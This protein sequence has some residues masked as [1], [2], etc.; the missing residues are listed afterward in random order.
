MDEGTRI[1]QILDPYAGRPHELIT[2]LREL[3]HALGYLSGPALTEVSRT[4]KVPESVVYGTATFYSMLSVR[5]RGQHIVRV[6]VS[7]PCHVEGAAAL[8]CALPEEL[9]VSYGQTTPDGFFTL[10]EA[11]CLGHCAEGPVVQ[12]DDNLYFQVTPE[13]LGEILASYRAGTPRPGQTSPILPPPQPGEV[14]IVLERVGQINPD[15]LEETRA[16]GAY[17]GLEKVLAEMT[18]AQLIELVQASGLQGR[19][20]AGFSTGLKWRF[21][22]QAAGDV[23]YV[24]ANADESE[25]GTFKDRLV[26]EGDPHLLLEGMAIAGY[27]IGAHEGYIYIR[28]EYAPAAQKLQQAVHQAEAAGLLGDNILGR[29]FSFHIDVHRGAGAYICGEETAL[30]ESLEGKRGEPRIRPPYPPQ[31]GLHDKP[32]A[33]NN[34]ETLCNVPA[35]VLKGAE[36]Y[37]ALGTEKSAGTKVFQLQGDV[38]RRGAVEVPM[39]ITLR[40][41]IDR[42]G[43]GVPGGRPIKLVQTGGTASTV[44]PPALLDMPMDFVS[45]RQGVSLGSGVVLVVAEGTACAAEFGAAVMRFFCHESCGKCVPCRIGSLRALEAFEAIM[46]GRGTPADMDHLEALVEGFAD[47]PFCALGQSIAVPLGSLLKY[48][49]DELSRHIAQ[50]GCGQAC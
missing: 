41:L 4:L 23:K 13:V 33:V 2:A 38:V 1:R 49:R 24:I 45:G 3:D 19:G 44:V 22:A 46:A 18:P 7:P 6:C 16:A 48:F 34:V 26:M 28:G 30:I 5:P 9:G 25:P 29:G 21:T 15:S 43:G 14:R 31:R 27:A 12:V 39:G 40:Q 47:A 37:R 42:Y 8:R 50:G 17:K 36:W 11:S 10:E 20:G 35:I 32:T